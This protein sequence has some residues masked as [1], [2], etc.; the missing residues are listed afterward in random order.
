VRVHLLV[1]R[2]CRPAAVTSEGAPVPFETVIVEESAYAAFGIALPA[3]ALDI[4]YTDA[5]QRP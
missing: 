4:A 1:P 5:R 3:G 2:G